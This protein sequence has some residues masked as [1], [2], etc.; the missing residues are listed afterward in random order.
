MPSAYVNAKRR[1]R[2]AAARE[3]VAA[4]RKAAHLVEIPDAQSWVDQFRTQK[5]PSALDLINS[6]E[7]IVYACASTN[8]TAVAE[9]PLRLYIQTAAGESTKH[10]Q[11]YK[12]VKA[13][14]SQRVRA[15][16]MKMARTGV[17]VDEVLDHPLLDLLEKPNRAFDG[18]TLHEITDLYLETAGNA[19]WWVER[20]MPEDVSSWVIWLLQ[21]PEVRPI[22]DKTT[23]LVVAYKYGGEDGPTY[24]AEQVVDFHFP[25]LRD[26][27]G[28]GW[29]PARAMWETINL[30]QKDKAHQQALLDNSAR[31][32]VVISPSDNAPLGPVGAKRLSQWFTRAFGK[33]RSGGVLVPESPVDVNILGFTARDMEAIKR[34]G[35]SRVELLNAY[36]IPPA[37]F[38]SNKSR[39]ELEA[40]LV[41]HGRKAVR[42][43]LRKRDAR[44]TQMLCPMCDPTGRLFFM[45]DDPVPEDAAARDTSDVAM[46]GANVR[47]INEVRRERGED[48]VEW[49]DEPL[50][51]GTKV[52]ISV[53][54]DPETYEPEPAPPPAPPVAPEETEE[55]QDDDDVAEDQGAKAVRRR[56][57]QKPPRGK[58]IRTAIIRVMERQR[59]E[60]ERQ[61]G[62]RAKALGQE[63]LNLDST[64]DLSCFDREDFDTIRPAVAFYVEAGGRRALARTGAMR[65][66]DVNLPEARRAIDAA[67]VKLCQ[68][69][70]RTTS[71]ELNDAIAQLRRN[72]ADEVVLGENTRQAL[73]EV[74]KNTFENAETWRAH[75]IAVTEASRAVHDGQ[76]L[77]AAQGGLTAGFEVMLSPTACDIC[78]D[79]HAESGGYID[80][81]TAM[82][83]VGSYDRD[84]PPYHPHC[85]CTF[86][87]RMKRVEE[88]ED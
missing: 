85:M 22:R 83:S 78:V 5:A 87:E 70:A 7:G 74:V 10:R 25:N 2:Y 69:T 40:A 59:R 48:D 86:T 36:D 71:L 9:V 31:P 56:R 1:K 84:L 21:S 81:E 52:P 66:W 24:P 33:G 16:E 13:S 35:V 6:F 3:A 76:I 19:Y 50:V 68:E 15:R 67:T 54:M 8:A 14:P 58:R 38:D 27:Y 65:F 60:V 34:Y 77:A 41:Q 20:P 61:L 88:L 51:D 47:T 43:R 18:S 75:R 44:L 17:E 26:P 57:W 62:L 30:L 72:I 42:P 39:A 73:T 53:A 29:S 37:I 63:S 82:G 23:N 80:L 79:A 28:D 49:G 46:L 55:G 12:T 64:I 4:A 45:S 11:R 32:D